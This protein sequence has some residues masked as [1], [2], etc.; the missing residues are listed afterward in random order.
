MKMFAMLL[1]ILSTIAINTSLDMDPSTN[2]NIDK[3]VQ[4]HVDLDLI[5]DFET[6]L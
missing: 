5:I 2:S 6:S 1:L 4:R 3:I